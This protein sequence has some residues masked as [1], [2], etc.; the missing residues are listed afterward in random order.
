MCDLHGI[1]LDLLHLDS[2]RISALDSARLSALHSGALLFSYAHARYDVSQTGLCP[3]CAAPDTPRHRLCICPKYQQLRIGREW[4]IDRWDS[5]ASC[6]THHL[7]PPECPQAAQ[8]H[9]HL[10]ALPGCASAFL[11][12]E[13][14]LERQHLFTHGSGF[15]SLHRTFGLASWALVNATTGHLIAGGPLKASS[16]LFRAAS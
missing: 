5:L 6:V 2:G 12:W 11:N 3:L 4:V 8:L 13:T 14:T 1:Y 16:K 9:Q 7:L 15:F 10:H